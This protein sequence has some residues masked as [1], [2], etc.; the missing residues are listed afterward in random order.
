MWVSYLIGF[1]YLYIISIHPPLR[2]LD[3]YQSLMLIYLGF[4]ASPPRE[5]YSAGIDLL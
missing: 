2:H 4:S 5:R 3:W 1:N